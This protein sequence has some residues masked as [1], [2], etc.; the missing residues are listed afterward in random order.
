MDLYIKLAI[1]F[2]PP[3]YTLYV[4]LKRLHDYIRCDKNDEAKRRKH[5]RQ[6]ICN[7]VLC[8]LFSSVIVAL[9]LFED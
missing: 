7:G 2:I 4:C 3:I 9:I 1:I 5:K 6:A 8:C